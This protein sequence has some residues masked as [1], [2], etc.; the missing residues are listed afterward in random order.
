MPGA[1]ERPKPN[2][3]IVML[4]R[5]LVTMAW[6]L[7]FRDLIYPERSTHT[8]MHGMPFDHARSQAC[9]RALE[10]GFEYLFFLDDDVIPPPDTL[11]RLIQHNRDIVCGM[12]FRRQEP[13]YPVMMKEIEGKGTQ[14]IAEFAPNS[15]VEA[16]LVG[17]GCMLIKRKVLEI[18]DPPWFVWK[19]DPFRFP[20]VP[21]FERCSE[22][23]DFC[24]KARK[25]GFKLYVDTSI[26]CLHAGLGVATPDGQSKPLQL[27]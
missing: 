7:G 9:K 12:Y 20:N 11:P 22:D 6:A 1:W 16:D 13:L 5:E 21:Q 25:L 3:L 10:L 14:W 15:L 2:V 23:Y 8:T 4:T 27:P 19:C 26:K 18:M 17:C 24:R